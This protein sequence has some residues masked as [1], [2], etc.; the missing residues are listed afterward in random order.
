MN[1]VSLRVSCTL[2]FVMM[3]LM[4]FAATA[5]P[6]LGQ[7]KGGPALTREKT[8]YALGVSIG[9][10]MK[11]LGVDIEPDM[12][13]RG[14][15]DT[16]RGQ[17]SMSDQEVKTTL[18]EY[19]KDLVKRLGEKNKREGA[20][21]LKENQQRKSVVTLA[22]GLQYFILREGKGPIPK[23]SDLVTIHYKARLIDG[24]E[25]ESSYWNNRPAEVAVNKSI[26]GWAEALTK[27]PVGSI[28]RLYIPSEL[29][30]GEAGAGT[31]I[32]PNAVIVCDLELLGVR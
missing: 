22:S 3:F 4:L 17:P 6:V 20:A 16:V 1:S 5:V 23:M 24:T 31:M 15:R 9:R 11:N 8:G 7:T 29:A 13:V 2:A 30:Y 32:G 25:F 10:N 26:K 21:F 27:M 28:W 18:D 14:I 12:I 19:E